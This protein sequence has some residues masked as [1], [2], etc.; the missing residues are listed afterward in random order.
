MS[1]GETGGAGEQ[2][3]AG[4]LPRLSEAAPPQPPRGSSAARFDSYFFSNLNFYV[5]FLIIKLGLLN[6]TLG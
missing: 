1:Q 5:K 4:C 3:A 2:G 6:Q